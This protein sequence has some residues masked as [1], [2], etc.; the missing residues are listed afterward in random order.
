MG[1]AVDE[2]VFP[3]FLRFLSAHAS[4]VAPSV[5]GSRTLDESGPRSQA[6]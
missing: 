3:T 2:D 4:E 1:K 5:N 6:T